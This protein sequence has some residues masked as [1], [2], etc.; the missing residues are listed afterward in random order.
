MDWQEN[1]W[2]HAFMKI[3]NFKNRLTC[4]TKIIAALQDL[5]ASLTL[6]SRRLTILLWRPFKPK[7]WSTAP[8]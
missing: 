2:S 1:G 3:G 8:F 4:D 7:L 5:T 6:I